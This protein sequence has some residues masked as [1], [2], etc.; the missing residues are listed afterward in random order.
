MTTT[1]KKK[2]KRQKNIKITF[3]QNLICGQSVFFNELYWAKTQKVHFLIFAHLTINKGF[4]TKKNKKKKHF[5]LVY[6]PLTR[7]WHQRFFWFC[8]QNV[9]LYVFFLHF[10]S[11]DWTFSICW[12]VDSKNACYLRET[13]I[14]FF[15][16]FRFP[17]SG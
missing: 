16:N 2:K 15:V 9:F 7:Y 17:T 6:P 4:N 12:I 10:R 1:C 14:H 5:A 8:G 3:F 13:K 11:T